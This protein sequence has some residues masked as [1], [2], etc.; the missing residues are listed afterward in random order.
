LRKATTNF[1]TSVRPSEWNDSALFRKFKLYSNLTRITGTL[2][3]DPSTFNKA[4][5]ILFSTR[6]ASQ[7]SCREYQYIHFTFNNSPPRKSYRLWDNVEKYGTARQA[8]DDNIGHNVMRF[9]CRT[10]Q[11][12]MQTH[13]E[14]VIL[15]HLP[16]QQWL[17]ERAS[18]LRLYVHCVSF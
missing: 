2:L 12:R 9:S 1:V 5:W 11:A 16:R 13:S 8:R 17:R 4:L 14:Y 10:T 7:K 15:I 18:M 3:E 6:I